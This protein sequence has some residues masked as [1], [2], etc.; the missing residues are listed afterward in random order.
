MKQPD[1]GLKDW[2]PFREAHSIDRAVIGLVFAQKVTDVPFDKIMKVSRDVTQKLGQFAEHQI[3]EV[4]V[5]V[6]AGAAKKGPTTNEGLEFAIHSAPAAVS[7]KITVRRDRILLETWAYTR[8]QPFVDRARVLIERLLPLYAASV[9]ILGVSVEYF[10]KFV[11]TVEEP[12][13]NEVLK[14]GD[15][16]VGQAFSEDFPW[17]SRAGWFDKTDEITL[18]LTNLDVSV[19]ETT[20]EEGATRRVINIRSMMRDTFGMNGMRR[21][22]EEEVTP[23]VVAERFDELHIRIK[24][25]LEGLLTDASID[26][27]ALKE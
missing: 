11:A 2:R 27:I 21:P 25:L 23:Q 12:K 5:E 10:D 18:C 13:I 22:T 4:S 19:G 20:T 16:L 14:K 6:S 17:H 7:E 1:K 24:G 9:P 26:R 15:F 8:W 3:H